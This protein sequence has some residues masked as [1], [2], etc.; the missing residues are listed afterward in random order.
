[1]GETEPG[2]GAEGMEARGRPL[3]QDAELAGNP[4]EGEGEPT[5]RWRAHQEPA[6]APRH[7]ECFGCIN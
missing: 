5:D 3:R 4:A 2:G 1:V 7:G 6:P